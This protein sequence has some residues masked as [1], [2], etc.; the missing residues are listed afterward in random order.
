MVL[1]VA[2]LTTY[3][4]NPRPLSYM[5]AIARIQFPDLERVIHITDPRQIAKLPWEF[6]RECVLLWPDPCGAGWLP[7]ERQVRQSAGLCRVTVL[8]GRQRRFDF[9]SR[10]H[11]QMRFRRMVEKSHVH[12]AVLAAVFLIVTPL[13][14]L[15]DAIAG[16][17]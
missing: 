15:S 3:Q 4:R 2:R 10:L 11:R 5:E 7:I 8:N 13:F 17:N 1:R 16:K 6:L 14:W 12:H 9:D